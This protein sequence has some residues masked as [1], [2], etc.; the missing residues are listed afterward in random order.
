MTATTL[1]CVK[2]AFVGVLWAVVAPLLDK[3]YA[4]CDELMPSDALDRLVSGDH[5]LW[6]AVTE[7]RD[8]LA[9]MTTRVKAMRSGRA[10]QILCCGGAQVAIWN[11]HMAEIETYA[12]TE[13]C[14]KITAEGRKG[15]LRLLN[16]FSSDSVIFEKALP[17]GQKGPADPADHPA[18]GPVVTGAAG[19][20]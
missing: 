5:V 12:R 18:I 17:N 11:H 4:A 6:L 1:V 20:S 8:I 9:A 19:A 10:I 7:E 2:P 14:V 16:G 13:G 15:W 3:G